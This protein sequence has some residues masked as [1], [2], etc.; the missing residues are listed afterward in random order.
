MSGIAIVAMLL[1]ANMRSARQAQSPQ[2]AVQPAK[3]IVSGTQIQPRESEWQDFRVPR[4]ASAVS[5]DG[6]AY[7]AAARG[8]KAA[9]GLKAHSRYIGLL[10]AQLWPIFF[11]QRV[12]KPTA[13]IHY[14]AR[15]LLA[16]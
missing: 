9:A 7:P 14:L 6:P 8:W 11:F 3:L 2:P 10:V 12:F 4:S 5:G 1:E 16:R 15:S 13:T